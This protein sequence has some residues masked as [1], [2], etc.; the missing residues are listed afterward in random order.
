[1]PLAHKPISFDRNKS[2]N[3]NLADVINTYW[4]RQ[5]AHT[6]GTPY[7]TSTL[8]NGVPRASNDPYYHHDAIIRVSRNGRNWMVKS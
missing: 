6:G 7:I 3:E 2:Y 8:Y 4:K 1:M 5:V